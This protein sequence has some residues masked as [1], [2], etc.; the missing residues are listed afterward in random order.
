MFKK[1]R[2]MFQSG[3]TDAFLKDWCLILSS[4]FISS[5]NDS[6]YMFKLILSI[7][8]WKMSKLKIFIG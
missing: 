5:D 4:H 7:S 1:F 2:L 3:K 8:N 6:D